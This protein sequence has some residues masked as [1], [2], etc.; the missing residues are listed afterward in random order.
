MDCNSITKLRI[1]ISLLLFQFY[2]IILFFFL[3]FKKKTLNSFL[4]H[5][6]I[7]EIDVFSKK[8][9]VMFSSCMARFLNEANQLFTFY[10]TMPNFNNPEKEAF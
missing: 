1:S 5:T 7:K 8:N 2:F 10:H 6:Y 9:E 4:D 3:I